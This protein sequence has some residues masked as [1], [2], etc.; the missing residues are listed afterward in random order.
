MQDKQKPRSV[1]LGLRKRGFEQNR[2]KHMIPQFKGKIYPDKTFSVWRPR[3]ET[4][5]AADKLHDRAWSEQIDSYVEIHRDY[6][7]VE[8]QRVSWLDG[9]VH[10]NRFINAQKLSREEIKGVRN[11]QDAVNT[12]NGERVGSSYKKAQTKGHARYGSKGIT[13]YGRKAVTCI[14]TL[15]QEDFGKE[16]LG[17]GTATLPGMGKVAI[18]TIMGKW[19]TVVKRFFEGIRRVLLGKG[20]KF[21]F[22]AVTEIQEGRFKREGIP[23][24]HLHWIYVCRDRRGSEFY[25]SANEIRNIWRRVLFNVLRKSY[26]ELDLDDI[27]TGASIDCCLVRKNA[28]AYLGKYISKGVKALEAMQEKGWDVYPAKWWSASHGCRKRFKESIRTMSAEAAEMIFYN[29]AAMIAE[30][31]LLSAHQHYVE[32]EMG[33]VCMAVCG[34]F[35]N[36]GL[37]SLPLDKLPLPPS[38]PWM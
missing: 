24:F 16:R 17:F 4:K 32:L 21:H 38:A 33:A 35:S 29:F 2:L 30:G 22:V 25:I 34:K 10:K 1:R 12:G 20:R 27:Q 37:Y 19:A 18:R 28:A 7:G 36:L 6:K 13:K 26:P 31:L 15:L 3:K 23:A 5:R 9:R 11:G 8:V 14:A